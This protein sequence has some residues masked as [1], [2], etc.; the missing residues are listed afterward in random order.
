[1]KVYLVRH[2]ESEANI[3]GLFSGITDTPLSK[4][5][6]D[7]ANEVSK[8]LS[9][10]KFDKIYS[11]PLYRAID[12]AKNITKYNKTDIEIV[13]DFIEMNF[14]LFEGLSYKQ[15]EEKYP[16]IFEK[17]QMNTSIFTFPEGENTKEFFDRV[18]K[19]YKEIIM[20]NKVD[21]ILIVAHSGVLRCILSSE[22][23]ERND[24]YW[25]YKIENC[26]I[27]IIEYSDGYQMLNAL[28]I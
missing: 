5:G 7:Q 10:I 8:K 25:K 23:S 12:T 19:K 2:G 15:I 26:K 4:K 11:S 17:W 6:I 24:H 16:E 3:K 1:M 18:Q 27:S 20:N 13:N 9:D 14:G 21:K 28:N 22:I